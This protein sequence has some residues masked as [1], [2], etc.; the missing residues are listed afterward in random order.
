[1]SF[2]KKN[3]DIISEDSAELNRIFLEGTHP[4]ADALSEK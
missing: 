1:M 4:T 3:K 2:L